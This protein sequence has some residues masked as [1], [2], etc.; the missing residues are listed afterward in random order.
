VNTLVQF[1]PDNH[2]VGVLSK[3]SRSPAPLTLVLP[4]AGLL[5]RTGPFRFH[6]DLSQRLAT[7]GI[8]TFRFDVPG[9]GEA[10]RLNGCDAR[11]ATLA[12]I[13]HLAT[14]HGCNRFAVGGLCSAAD[15]GWSA[16]VSDERVIAILMLDGISFHGPWFH[17]A[18]IRRVIQRLPREGWGMLQRFAGR[19]L[20]RERPLS[21][22]DFRDWPQLSEARQQ[23]SALVDRGVHSLW[24]YTGTYSERFLHPRQFVWSFGAPA[25]HPRT[26]L[27]YW[28]DCDHLFYAKAHRNRLLDTVDSWLDSVV[29]HDGLAS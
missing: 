2:L 14:H 1:G 4:S 22:S 17:L 16:A 21:A 5:P 8:Q 19:T 18:R 11:A 23:F 10:P 26:T 27:H 3:V 12:A 6:V 20:R 29:L 13:D 9:V 15:I 7:R 28:E 24:V 25:R